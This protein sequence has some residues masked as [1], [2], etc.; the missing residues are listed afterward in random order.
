MMNQ[1]SPI[2]VPDNAPFTAEQKAWLNRFLPGM[3]R[4]QITWL[5]GFIAGMTA[6]GIQ[7]G[8]SSLAEPGA[9]AV[10]AAVAAPAEKVAVTILYGT[11]SG[12]TEMLA[13]E[14]KKEAE[15]RGFA[16]V[17]KN[18]EDF[19]PEK[20]P[21]QKNLLVLVSTWGEGDPP[22]PA[23]SFYETVMSDKAPRLDQVNFS[24]LALGDTSYAHFCKM[25]KDFDNRLEELGGTRMHPR[26]DCDV[27]FDAPFKEWMEAVF[28]V[29]SQQ[30]A[31]PA[32]EAATAG[33]A[34][35]AP[36]APAAGGYS[37]KN[38]FPAQIL[39]N[40][41][42]TGEGGETVRPSNKDT[43]HIELSLEGSQLTYEPGDALGVYASN[44]PE[45]VDDILEITGLSAKESV[46]LPDGG[47]APLREALIRDYD[48]TGLSQFFLKKYGERAKSKHLDAL[49]D[50]KNSGRLNDYLA[51][52][53]IADALADFPIRDLAAEELVSLLRK[54]PPRL[55]SI[56]SSL[57]AHPEEVHLAV[58]VVRFDAAGKLRKGVC[59]TYLAERV[60]GDTPVPVY[61]HPNKN[62]K[63]PAD[64]DTPVIMV[65]PGTGIAPFRAFV[66]ERAV[67]G[68]KGSNWLFFG[69]QYFQTDF[70][71]QL[72]WQ[73]YLSKG[74]LTRLDVAFSRDSKEKVYV[75]HRM[76]EK[77]KDL[78]RWLEEGAH[79]YVCGDAGRMAK[80]VHDTLHKIAQEEGGMSVE[81]ADEYVRALQ[82]EKRYQRDVY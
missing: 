79:F 59:S 49:L 66:E 71:Y 39:E 16:P 3:T 10:P 28:A 13:Q 12:N 73:E 7:G 26:Q 36:G 65:G 48:V 24:V 74:V 27:D 38:P 19:P 4:E 77:R 33:L 63:L 25:G 81:A 6:A 11:E 8:S 9:A 54:M 80:D 67:T 78:F 1:S 62:F 50:T 2:I 76:W 58:G 21:S 22:S 30:K 31:Q 15:K 75:Q 51:G 23:E 40:I 68:A 43:R 72:E 60:N 29:L 34:E 57:K 70:L 45:V 46:S 55:Y 18:M 41:K 5:N 35:P 37:R 64:S 56:A 32:P 20:L 53:E 69:E 42:L 17:V 61:V 52:R 82:K 47:E 14:M 44:C